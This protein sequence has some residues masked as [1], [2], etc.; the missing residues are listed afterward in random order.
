[1]TTIAEGAG[2][3]SATAAQGKRWLAG[4]VVFVAVTIDHFDNAIGIVYA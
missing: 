1:V 2:G 4:Q 3:G